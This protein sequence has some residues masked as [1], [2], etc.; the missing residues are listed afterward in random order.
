MT[1]SRRH[2][3]TGIGAATAFAYV[4][5][6]RA[7]ALARSSLLYPPMDLSYFDRPLDHGP[8]EITLGATA[9]ISGGNHQQ[10]IGAVSALGYPGI[11]L[12]SDTLKEFPDPHALKDLLA[13]HRLTLVALSSGSVPLDSR[14]ETET[15]EAYV[16]NARYLRA[17]GGKYLLVAGAI[18]KGHD[19]T[20]SEYK[21]EGQFLTEVG[22]RAADY[23]I[24]TGFHN[25]MATIGQTPRQ[26]DS[27]LAAAD[28]RYVK[29]GLDVPHYLQGGGDPAEAIRMC[30]K[31]LLCVHL[32]GVKTTVAKGE[33]QTADLHRG[34]SDFG[35]ITEALHSTN[36]R[37]WSF[38]GLDGHESTA[39]SVEYLT[40]KLG[41]QA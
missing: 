16:R 33:Y 41:V 20:A 27:V 40:K 31:R 13:Q 21:R 32:I 29:L 38:V 34:K 26:V 3:L 22:K 7:N 28:A 24:Q 10:V 12:D 17:A 37:G 8:G 19:F 9:T 14:I 18:A 4:G 2:F 39:M 5:E 25:R 36:F 1:H 30:D 23:G 11:H 15:I 35:Q 6:S